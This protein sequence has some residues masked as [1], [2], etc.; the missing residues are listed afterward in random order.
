MARS[1]TEVINV[2][3][4]K[5]VVTKIFV[6]SDK[7]LKFGLKVPTTGNGH[8]FL[9]LTAFKKEFENNEL[10]VI[11]EGF[12]IEFEGMLYTSSYDGKNGKVYNTEIIVKKVI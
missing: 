3:R 11:D 9:T 12:N 10:D 8:A 1:T 5:G 2:A 4:V 6:D 7:V